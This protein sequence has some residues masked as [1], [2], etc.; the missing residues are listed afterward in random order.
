MVLVNVLSEYIQEEGKVF[1][2]QFSKSLQ[3]H[4]GK[5]SFF[6]ILQVLNQELACRGF[7][8]WMK[9]DGKQSGGDFSCG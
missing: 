4:D 5:P 6:D 8:K 2:S 9:S 3:L 1:I 7:T